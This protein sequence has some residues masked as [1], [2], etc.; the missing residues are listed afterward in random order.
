MNRS[1]VR[2]LVCAIIGIT[3]IGCGKVGDAPEARTGDAVDVQKTVGGIYTIDT[4][5]SSITWKAAKVTRAHD[6]GFRTFEGT[7]TVDGDSVTAVNL[8]ID[9]ASIW[10]DPDDLTRHLK[11][12][13]F[14]A[15]EK[16][17]TATFEASQFVRT[18]SVPGATHIVTGN[19]TIRGNKHG[20]TF[21]ATIHVSPQEVT[22]KADFK[23]NRKDWGIV[24]PGAP[25]DLI[26]DDVRIIFDITAAP[27]AVQAGL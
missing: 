5:K 4:S 10:T 7:V 23:I 13:D 22:A 14:F 26:Y 20:V 6:G 24:Y 12:D 8:T 19:L 1:I 3:A 18:D 9:A 21:P 25:D 27:S 16:Y 11:T 17:P 2:A 15:V